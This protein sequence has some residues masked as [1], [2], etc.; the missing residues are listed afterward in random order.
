RLEADETGQSTGATSGSTAGS[1]Y[2]SDT[3]SY[4]ALTTSTASTAGASPGSGGASP[5]S[6]LSAAQK[7][8]LDAQKAVD[9]AQAAVD[10]AEHALTEA[11]TQ[12]TSLRDAQR[13][14]CATS[15]DGSTGPTTAG[16]TSARAD[17][18]AYAD[19]LAAANAAVSSAVADQDAALAQLDKAI[20]AL[21][22]LLGSLS[23]S[24]GTT[25]R[26]GGTGTTSG[27][28]TTGGTGNK[29]GGAGNKTGGTGNQTGGTGN[30][31]GGTGTTGGTGSSTPSTGSTGT[32]PTA[33]AAQLASDQAAIDAAA[34]QLRAA[35]QD[36]QAASLRS[37][38]SG[39]VAAVGLTVG[40]S[41]SGT[42]T[43]VG[44]GVP[45]VT[46]A[47]PLAQID[48]IKK[49]QATSVAV[50]GVSRPLTGKVSTIG[51]LSS[52][53][54]S[55]TTFPVTV[56]LGADTPHLYDGAGAD[57]TITTGTA[58][59]V[60]TVPNSAIH[61]LTRG[62]HTVTVLRDGRT[63]TVSVTLGVAGAAVTE[64]RS[65]LEAGDRVVLADYGQALPSST[66][67]S[68]TN[69]ISRLLGGGGGGGGT[70][71]A[72]PRGN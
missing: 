35:R 67:D 45:K 8:V 47:V 40:G 70:F 22:K 1:G 27:T 10:S 69:R 18:E 16:C 64:V 19:D 9:S 59:D 25:G 42:I 23:S 71:P 28:G 44:T 5:S 68:T 50:D 17:F 41:A 24:G 61:T 66:S 54:G 38:I 15:A 32:T 48:L 4:T 57:V 11:V 13:T 43:I 21:D 37:P 29:T 6:S 34:A 56:Q 3:A 51:M 36:R 63:S 33:S 49:G 7:A 30:Q 12:N 52:T 20:A 53:S 65:G 72:F 14:A 58:Q 60:L 39:V 2:S 55:Q 31:T 62:L 26:T 46:I